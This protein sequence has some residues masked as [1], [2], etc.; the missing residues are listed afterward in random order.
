MYFDLWPYLLWPLDFQIQ[1]R[2]VSA[3]T[4]WGNTVIDFFSNF[5]ALSPRVD[6][7]LIFEKSTPCVARKIQVWNRPK[8]KFVQLDFSNLIFQCRSIGGP[9]NLDFKR[10]NVIDQSAAMFTRCLPHSIAHD[11]AIWGWHFPKYGLS[12]NPSIWQVERTYLSILLLS[13]QQDQCP[14]A[15]IIYLI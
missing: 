5:V 14:H 2:I 15:R 13:T 10:L 11:A 6:L 7:H 3:E 8:I 12:R 1:K 4:I 9:E